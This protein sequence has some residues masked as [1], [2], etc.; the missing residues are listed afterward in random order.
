[1]GIPSNAEQT[2][3]IDPE[4]FVGETVFERAILGEEAPVRECMYCKIN[5]NLIL[6]CPR[7]TSYQTDLPY[8]HPENP[9]ADLQLCPDCAQQHLEEM[10]DR[11][12]EYYSGLL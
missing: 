1:M 5:S 12:A 3:Y 6:D 2:V 9:N 11:W 10:N 4:K 8:D 7:M